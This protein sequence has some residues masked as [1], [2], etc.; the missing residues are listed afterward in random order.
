MPWCSKHFAVFTM[1]RSGFT[2]V[3]VLVAGV[4]LL[5]L[6]V[7]Y[8]YQRL[9]VN[10]F[11]QFTPSPSNT[12]NTPVPIAS[13][14]ANTPLPTIKSTYASPTAVPILKPTATPSPTPKIVFGNGTGKICGYARAEFGCGGDA[15]KAVSIIEVTADNKTLATTTTNQDGA[16]SINVPFGQYTVKAHREYATYFNGFAYVTVTQEG[17]TN[18]I[19]SMSSTLDGGMR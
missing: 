16:F 10:R 18:T 2:L 11:Q 15:C 13:N 12:N 3:H 14:G 6:I 17:C 1:N 8:G 9:G 5:T 7:G 4:I 19:V